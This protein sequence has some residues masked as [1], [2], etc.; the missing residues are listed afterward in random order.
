MLEEIR[1]RGLG[2][3]AEAVLPLEPGLTVLTG[4]TGAG[5]TMLLSA[6]NLLCGG[7][8]DPSLVR[9]EVTQA[10]VEGRV[11]IEAGRELDRAREAGADVDDDG[12]LLVRRS[13]GADGR[14][15]AVLGGAGVPNGVLAEVVA[16]RIV[17]HGQADQQR[18]SSPAQQR[19]IL[20]RYAGPAAAEALAAY[21][22]A[23]ATAQEAAARERLLDEAALTGAAD[24]DR[25]RFVCERIEALA[26]R[27]GEDG[28][29]VNEIGRLAHVES[30]AE[31]VAGAYEVLDGSEGAS[32][33]AESPG[34]EAL[35]A[36]GARLL[37]SQS[38]HDPRVGEFADRMHE[39]AIVADELRGDLTSY[40]DSLAA[41]PAALQRAN[42]RLAAL[43]AAGNAYVPHNPTADG[44]IAWSKDAAQQ[45]YDLEH[46]EDQRAAARVARE[47]ALAVLEKAALRL[48]EER[49]A[50]AVRLSELATREFAGLALGGAR[51]DVEVTPIDPGPYGADAVVF[52]FTAHAGAPTRPVG[53]GA[54]GG[55]LSRIMLA[56]EVV[57][58]GADP[59]PTMV[60]DEVDAGVGGQA[61]VEVGAR[62]ARLAEHHQVLV[63]THL[64]QVAA[65]A[66]HH[67]RV[68]KGATGGVGVSDVDVLGGEDR[69]VELARMLGGQSESDVAREHA[70]ELLAAAASRR[71]S[72]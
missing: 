35:L 72:W 66:D 9:A 10:S 32:G 56:L 61:A 22:E 21:Q 45:L 18:L 51:L 14:S 1:I 39:L 3:I 69:I 43:R 57:L 42:E 62:L 19:D 46:R 17:V 36:Q 54:S 30:L 28:E 65:F 48:R 2:V 59:V 63:V 70:R 64:A 6:L 31:A 53:R 33:E 29:L 38:V 55:E 20:D 15:R 44:L 11:Q 24:V 47:Q 40:R 52:G 67:V 27:P 68:R 16:S 41:D 7:R 49:T 34:A 13:V 50:A 5:K 37:A 58:A 8:A 71:H 25:L 4:E 26:P 23:Y 60:F 12:A